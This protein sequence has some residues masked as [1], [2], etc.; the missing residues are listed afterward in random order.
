MVSA[1]RLAA[2]AIRERLRIWAM[3]DAKMKRQAIPMGKKSVGKNFDKKKAM[4]PS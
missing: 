3:S 2:I 4:N 1:A